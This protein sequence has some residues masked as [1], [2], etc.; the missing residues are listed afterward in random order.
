MINWGFSKDRRWPLVDETALSCA[1]YP[2]ENAERRIMGVGQQRQME[3]LDCSN[4]VFS[5]A[6]K[7]ALQRFQP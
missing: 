7:V 5:K 3:I 6:P 2:A 1:G 4:L